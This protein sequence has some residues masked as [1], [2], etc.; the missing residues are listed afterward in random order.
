MAVT[1]R[2]LGRSGIEVSALGMGCWAIGGPWS[3]GSQPLGWGA[4]DDAESVRALRRALEVGITFFDTA[5]TYGAGH[6][7][8]ILGRALAGGRRDGAVIATKWGYTFDEATRQATGQDATPAHLRRAVTDSLRRLGTDR[9]DLY[10]LHLGDLPV[11]RA[12]ELLVT[13]EEL[14]AEGSVRSYGW[15]TDRP[16]RAAAWG[17]DGAHASAVQHTLSVLQDAPALLAVCATYDLASVNRGPL[18][19]GLLTGK[20]TAASTLARDDVRGVAPGWLEWFRSGR[21]AP[22]WLRR[23]AAVRGALTADGRSLAQGALGW[24]WARSDRTVPIPGCR[25]VAQVEENAA[26]LGRGPLPPDQFAEVERQLAAL[27]AAALRDA[28]R[29]R[30]SAPTAPLARP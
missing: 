3:E 6:S 7:E 13:L 8:R 9:I 21:P 23:V 27:R 5:D 14:V 17:R 2:R 20:Y 10:Q 12:G 16:D 25:T 11:S 1:T 4:V 30:W 18:G 26:A 22:E 24:I 15:S 19:M 29:P 28:D